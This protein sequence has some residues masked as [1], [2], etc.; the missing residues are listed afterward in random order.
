MPRPD[1][2]DRLYAM[3]EGHDR[4]KRI[5]S[6]QNVNAGKRPTSDW[7]LIAILDPDLDVVIAAVE[8]L[9]LQMNGNGVESLF[10]HDASDSEI[11]ALIEA[12]GQ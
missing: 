12:V 7:K 3:M 10:I 4:A 8:E 1:L 5:R 11:N 2:P 6:S 9:H